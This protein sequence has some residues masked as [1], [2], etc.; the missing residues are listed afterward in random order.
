MIKLMV[1]GG[2]EKELSGGELLRWCWWR[3][4]GGWG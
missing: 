3:R 4:L 2:E 1:S